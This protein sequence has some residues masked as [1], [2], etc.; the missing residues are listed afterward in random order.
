MDVECVFIGGKINFGHFMIEALARVSTLSWAPSLQTLP[1]AVYEDLPRNHVEFLELLGY[2]ADRRIAVSRQGPASFT[3]VWLLSA[4]ICRTSV[5]AF[6]YIWPS[7]IWGLRA[8]MAY[9]APGDVKHQKRL[10][11]PRRGARWRRLVNES[12]VQVTLS[13]FG[14]E[15]VDLATDGAEDQ[16]RRVAAAEMIV[17]SQGAAGAIT[18][19]SSPHCVVIEL[20]PPRFAATLGPTAFSAVL[21][22]PY[23]RIVGRV[24]T[25]DEAAAVGLPPNQSTQTIDRDYVI[26]LA[27][28]ETALMA[29][30][31]YLKQGPANSP[32][33]MPPMNNMTRS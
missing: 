21:N 27:E 7:S 8:A 17:V 24:A 25:A 4:P 29:A 31:T 2:T 28:L 20:M 3:R 1:I 33:M 32:P 5:T 9:L 6:P 15:S 19:F 10:F 22:Q 26:D 30:D 16:I 14:F 11:I 18:V 23:H 13:K 12:S